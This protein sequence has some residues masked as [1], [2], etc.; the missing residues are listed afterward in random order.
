MSETVIRCRAII[1]NYAFVLVL[2]LV[3]FSLEVERVI[4]LFYYFIIYCYFII[5]IIFLFVLVFL[6][7]EVRGTCN[8]LFTL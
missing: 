6:S 5:F 1:L 3:F 4:L 2:V 8:R 7:L